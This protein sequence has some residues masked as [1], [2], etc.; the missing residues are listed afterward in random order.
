MDKEIERQFFS[1]NELLKKGTSVL[2][3]SHKISS[4]LLAKQ[5]KE[6]DLKHSPPPQERTVNS[7]N[8]QIDNSRYAVEGPHTTNMS[9]PTYPR[10]KRSLTYNDRI[11]AGNLE[12]EE[13]ELVIVW[14]TAPSHTNSVRGN[15]N[16]NLL[17]FESKELSDLVRV[18]EKSTSISCSNEVERSLV[19]IKS[20]LPDN[21]KRDSDDV[22]SGIC[23]EHSVRSH[24]TPEKVDEIPS[25]WK[26]NFL[27]TKRAADDDRF[28][29]TVT[30][31][32]T[33]SDLNNRLSID[34]TNSSART[35]VYHRKTNS[36]KQESNLSPQKKYAN[37]ATI[38]LTRV[39]KRKVINLVTRNIAVS[40]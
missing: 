14:S 16:N 8:M 33:G 37:F 23:V 40:C 9:T 27:N 13:R 7:A 3:N 11:C 29:H 31:K 20:C 5:T 38:L 22:I 2:F 4:P 15:L 35:R 17:K 39:K 19:K 21:S 30:S 6:N 32:T 36:R 18:P 24:V 34:E 26:S 28:T 12:K 25:Q 1:G 10:N